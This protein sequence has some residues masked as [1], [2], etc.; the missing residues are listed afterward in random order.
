MVREEK[1]VDINYDYCKGCGICS[2]EC[3]VEAIK[4]MEEGEYLAKKR[5]GK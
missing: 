5:E 4:M 2:R 1:M 3:P